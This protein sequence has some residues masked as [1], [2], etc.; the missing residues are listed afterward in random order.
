MMA[1][2]K[3]IFGVARLGIITEAELG[4]EILMTFVP[5]AQRLNRMSDGAYGEKLQAPL[6]YQTLTCHR[7]I[8]PDHWTSTPDCPV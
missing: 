2:R 5:Y 8:V 3:F 7:Q 6:A 4:K 1:D